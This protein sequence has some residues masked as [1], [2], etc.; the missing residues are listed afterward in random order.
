[1]N[2]H[3]SPREFQILG[4]QIINRLS[5]FLD[6][7]ENN[8]ITPAENAEEV[9]KVLSQ[10][11]LPIEGSPPEK[12][13]IS[14]IENLINH[15]L[16]NGHP[17]FMGYITSAA[18]PIGAL[19]DLIAS[20]INQ[21]TGAWQL[22][23]L[24]SE[25]ERQTIQWIAEFIGYDKGCGGILMSGGNMA[26]FVGLLTA[27]KSKGHQDIQK[28]GLHPVSQRMLMYASEETHTWIE[29]AA[30]LFGFG[31]DAIRWIKT[32]EAR[33]MDV[34]V[35]EETIINDEK[36]GGHPFLV[37]GTAGSVGLGVVDPL[38]KISNICKK[39]DLWFHVDG[40]YGAPAAGQDNAPGQLKALRLA[41]SVALDPHKWF[42]SALEVGCVLVK[43]PRMML[44]TFSHHPDYYEFGMEGRE[45]NYYEYGFQNSRGFR[46]LKVWLSFQ[47][48]G[49]KGFVK[50]IEK[51]IHLSRLLVEKMKR[52]PAIVPFMNNLSITSFSY[53]PEYI[54]GKEEA[55]QDN[56]NELNKKILQ[57]VQN[58]GKAFISNALVNGRYLLRAC[59]VNFRTREK[60]L[61][62]LLDLVNKFGAV[63]EGQ[64]VS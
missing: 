49:K 57:E 62:I 53:I 35:L 52:Y 8:P 22:S 45:I 56:L 37:I 47:L 24:A 11:E 14:T 43:D 38:D 39:H 13:L 44:E 21:N 34:Q 59:L 54:Q 12:L 63:L 2:E 23:P 19:A 60:D 32:N 55:H 29:K 16:F 50:L 41:D 4:H 17:G 27:R 5:R 48:L 9:Q 40:A 30:D 1:M 31:T 7:I 10:R 61:D 51:D 42:Y 58:S 15:S 18:L 36:N 25:I 3:L 26:N 46:A 64:Q 28:T 33:E 6:T 20:A